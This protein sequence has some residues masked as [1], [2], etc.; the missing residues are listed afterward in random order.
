MSIC[1]GCVV[2]QISATAPAIPDDVVDK[3]TQLARWQKQNPGLVFADRNF[4]LI[5]VRN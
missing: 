4:K 3:I 5:M 2:S 1:T